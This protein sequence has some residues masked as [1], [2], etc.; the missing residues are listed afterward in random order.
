M[1]L[2]SRRSWLPTVWL[3]WAR[4]DRAASS[5][6]THAHARGSTRWS[7]TYS[8]STPATSSSSIPATGFSRIEG[9]DA[10]R[11][12]VSMDAPR[13]Q[14]SPAF[15]QYCA[16]IHQYIS[17]KLALRARRA[18]LNLLQDNYSVDVNGVVMLSQI[19]FD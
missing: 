17:E 16:G 13:W 2:S 15:C 12:S 10:V 11:S 9:K 3:H 18:L 6:R 7:A 5:P 1:N 14:F 4:S 19:N 8:L